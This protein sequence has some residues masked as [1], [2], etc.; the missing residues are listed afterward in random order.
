[1]NNKKS[2]TFKSKKH[3]TYKWREPIIRYRE[4]DFY[5]TPGLHYCNCME[6]KVF[7]DLDSSFVY[8]RMSNNPKIEVIKEMGREVLAN[9][10]LRSRIN[11]SMM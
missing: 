1:M 11:L 3:I 5:F 8:Y 9:R 2:L 7:V 6:D 10:K 4:W